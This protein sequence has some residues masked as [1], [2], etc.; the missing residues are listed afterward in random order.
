ML[1]IV[2]VTLEA[3]RLGHVM[4]INYTQVSGSLEVIQDK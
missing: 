4:V 2:S 3:T 1:S